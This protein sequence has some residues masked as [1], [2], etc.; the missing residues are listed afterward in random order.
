MGAAAEIRRQT[1]IRIRERNPGVIYYLDSSAVVKAFSAESGSETVI[2]IL[3]SGVP[4]FSSLVMYPEVLFALRR[5]RH[6]KEISEDEFES[7]RTRFEQRWG[8]FNTIE[9]GPALGFLRERAIRYPLRALDAIH[10]SSALWAKERI[11]RDCRFLCSDLELLKVAAQEGL[12]IINPERPDSSPTAS[13]PSS[14]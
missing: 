12:E 8:Y 2:Q 13:S 9:L 6:R 3:K 7:G 4:A 5:K 10:L 1:L 11:D 14:V